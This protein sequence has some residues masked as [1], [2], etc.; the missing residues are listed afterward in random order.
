MTSS[1]VNTVPYP[2]TFDQPPVEVRGTAKDEAQISLKH[3]RGKIP[4]LQA[5]K[6][7]ASMQEAHR[8]SSK[9]V[10]TTCTY[11]SLS[12]RLV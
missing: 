11:D 1:I 4:S 3:V 7:R 10:A 2:F 8:D 12:T 5:S 9:I 6:V